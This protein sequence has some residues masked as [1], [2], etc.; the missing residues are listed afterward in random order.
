MPA[1]LNLVGTRFGKLLVTG[2]APSEKRHARWTCECDC[3][4]TIIVE[5]RMLRSNGKTCC[6]CDT[7]A[8]IS[9][10]S[11]NATHRMSK[12]PTYKS[13]NMM[14]SRCKN[15]NY[16]HYAYYGG[17]G[18][19]VCDRW[20]SFEAFLEDMG[21]RPAGATLDRIDTDK[22]YCKENCRWASREEQVKNRRN[23]VWLEHNG[24]KRIASEW[25]DLLGIRRSGIY[26]A[27]NSGESFDEFLARRGICEPSGF[28]SVM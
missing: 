9:R 13:W 1:R 28:E 20:N 6:G 2:I 4:S 8:K 15:P 14:H 26:V 11:K 12:S 24:E 19:K 5:T 17:R 25:V 22:D 16:T 3:G 27:L 7:N 18:I 10:N 21:E 23:N